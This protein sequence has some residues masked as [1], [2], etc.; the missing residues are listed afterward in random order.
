MNI[1]LQK[2]LAFIDLETTGLNVA[3]DRI[4]EISILKVH[5]DGKED[6]KTLR[7]NPTISIPKEASDIHGITDE[8][9]KNE[10]T[11]N[12]IAKSIVKFLEG[13]DIAGFNSNKFDIPLLVE[14]FLRVDVDFDTKKR[15]FIDVQT[16][17]HKMEKR[18]LVAAYKYYC[19]KELKDAHSAEADTYATYEV[20]KSQIERYNG[21][22]YTDIKGN[23]SKPITNNIS[24]LSEFSSHTK[25][26]DFIGRIVYNEDGEEIFNFGKH[27][28]K[29]V[30]EVLEK[31]P[32]YFS[33]ILNGEFPLYTKKVLTAI[34]LRKFNEK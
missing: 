14:E 29:T 3:K 2:P 32:G 28:G 4:V 16:I 33:W 6:I 10:P 15:K 1:N 34:K 5:P 23:S 13:C 18:T 27:K 24:D 20:L 31:E 7:V 26:V 19:N 11:F 30:E 12:S 25:N 22:E 21:V 9:I 17:F 8:D